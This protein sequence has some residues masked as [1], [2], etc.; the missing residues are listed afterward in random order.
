MWWGHGVKV[1]YLTTG[2]LTDML[3]RSMK[4]GQNKFAVRSQPKP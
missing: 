4:H 3:K 1:I 2:D